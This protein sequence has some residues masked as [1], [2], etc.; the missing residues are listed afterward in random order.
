MFGIAKE[1][2]QKLNKL[3]E[4]ESEIMQIEHNWDTAK[5][6]TESLSESLKEI[7]RLIKQ[8][9]IVFIEDKE[10]PVAFLGWKIFVRGK[11]EEKD[12]ITKII[13]EGYQPYFFS[14][15]TRPI[16][17]L[18]YMLHLAFGLSNL[19]FAKEITKLTKE[20]VRQISELHSEI[21]ETKEEQR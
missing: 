14:K 18:C 5:A 11:P 3:A 10:R 8:T 17:V 12:Q 2:Q 6:F 9:E 1:I 4:M 16:G 20:T 7:T 21:E 13:K 19:S 15:L